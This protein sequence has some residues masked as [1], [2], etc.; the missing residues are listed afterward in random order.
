MVR[1]VD[2]HPK[3]KAKAGPYYYSWAGISGFYRKY[4]LKAVRVRVEVNGETVEGVTAIAQNSDPLTYFASKPIRVCEGAR[5]VD[6]A[7]RE[8]GAATAAEA[9]VQSTIRQVAADDE[10]PGTF[11]GGGACDHRFVSWQGEQRRWATFGLRDPAVAEGGIKRAIGESAIREPLG[12]PEELLAWPATRIVPSSRTARPLADTSSSLP[13]V[14]VRTTP[15]LPKLGSRLPFACKRATASSELLPTSLA[16]G[17]YSRTRLAGCDQGLRKRR[18]GGPSPTHG[19]PRRRPSAPAWR[20][21]R[22][23]R[24]AVRRS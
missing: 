22:R 18:R 6:V 17:P 4:L 2:E 1:R 7:D 16:Q 21:R 3:L 23:T 19:G 15:P 8:D 10:V 20:R 24:A 12:D 14:W 5:V 13:S 9:R 11:E